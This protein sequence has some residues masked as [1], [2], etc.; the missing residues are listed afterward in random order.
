MNSFK[1]WFSEWDF[2]RIV[3]TILTI[4]LTIAYFSTKEEMYLVGAIFLGVQAIFNI[5]C[6][7]NACQTNIPQRKE[8]EIIKTEKLKTDK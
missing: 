3:R 2:A 5:G 4:V 6:A 7:G 8:S 1:K